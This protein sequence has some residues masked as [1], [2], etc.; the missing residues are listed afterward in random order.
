MDGPALYMAVYQTK[1]P[2]PRSRAS[3]KADFLNGANH[4]TLL[5]NPVLFTT[6]TAPLRVLS[7]R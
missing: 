7:G 3:V 4:L 2:A 1:F 6:S 5:V